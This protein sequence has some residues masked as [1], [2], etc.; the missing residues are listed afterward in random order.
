[1]KTSGATVATILGGA[2]PQRVAAVGGRRKGAPKKQ[3]V[4]KPAAAVA[5]QPYSVDII[6]GDKRT[7]E[8]FK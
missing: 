7:K 3:A 4:A 5:V 2:T 8:E 1:V 6:Q